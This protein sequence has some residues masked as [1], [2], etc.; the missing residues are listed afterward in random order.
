MARVMPLF[1][2]YEKPWLLSRSFGQ[3]KHFVGVNKN[4]KE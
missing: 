3:P 1:V 4:L 2:V